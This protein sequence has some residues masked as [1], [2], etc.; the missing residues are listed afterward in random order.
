MD[1]TRDRL[2]WV[3]PEAV[4]QDGIDGMQGPKT[5]RCRQSS[6]IGIWKTRWQISE[7]DSMW[8]VLHGQL[9]AASS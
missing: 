1:G 7:T 3:V 6:V 4:A 2:C 5:H 9:L 8:P